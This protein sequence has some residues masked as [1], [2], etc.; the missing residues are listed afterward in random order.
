MGVVL[1]AW[2]L[3]RFFAPPSL[4]LRGF[5]PVPGGGR[6]GISCSLPPEVGEMGSAG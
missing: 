1:A 5:S 2:R 4:P 3:A 6:D